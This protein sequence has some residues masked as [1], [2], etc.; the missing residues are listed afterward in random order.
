VEYAS[1]FPQK[2]FRFRVAGLGGE[3]IRQGTEQIEIY[4]FVGRKIFDA[5]ENDQLDAAEWIGPFEDLAINLHLAKGVGYYYYPGWWDP[6]TT[7]EFQVNLKAWKN[8]P[9]PYKTM[10]KAACHQACEAIH[11]YYDEQN[12]KSLKI[13]Q[14]QKSIIIKKFPPKLMQAMQ[15]E[16]SSLLDRMFGVRS[17]ASPPAKNSIKNG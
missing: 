12:A 15:E 5:L 10:F 1:L 14:Q 3:I 13:I 4:D 7:Y 2:K 11:A 16:T 6:G 8:L 9:P 17:D